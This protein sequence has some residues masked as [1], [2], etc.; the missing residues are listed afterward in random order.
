MSDLHQ[1]IEAMLARRTTCAVE[2]Q[3][4]GGFR[5]RRDGKRLTDKSFGRDKAIQLFQ[6]LVTNR[7][8]H[9]LHREQIMDRIW[10]DNNEQTFKVSLH[11]IGKALEP[12]KERRAPSKFIQRQGI[13]YQLRT[14]D[15][16]I[17]ADDLEQLIA[18]GN[19]AILQDKPL[20]IRAYQAAAQLYEGPYLPDRLYEDWTSAERERLRVL[21]LGVMVTLAELY[22]DN[23]PLESIR[24]TQRALQ[25]DNT[26]EE[27]YRIQMQAYLAKGN[28][29]QALKTYQQ[30]ANILE[31][32]FGVRPLPETRQVH[33][34]IL[35]R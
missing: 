15:L 5:V 9:A 22:L 12:D 34:T 2:V 24:L 26:W 11:G 33:D 17:D 10:E 14:D 16:W 28:R 18:L 30:C 19:Q 23:N 7:D 32:E 31:E 1:Q 8:R 21:A 4:L 20:A 6:F 29:P 27:A 3:T 25:I 13:S 35:S